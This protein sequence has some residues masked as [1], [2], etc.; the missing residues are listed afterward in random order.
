[1]AAIESTRFEVVPYSI[2]NLTDIL[3]GVSGTPREEVEGKHHY[4]YLDEYFEELEAS[5]ILVEPEYVD[6]DFLED[7]AEY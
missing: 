4:H 5:T 7:F 3:A 6:H 1:M 2:D